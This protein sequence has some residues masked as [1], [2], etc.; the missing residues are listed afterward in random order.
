M[1]WC[2]SDNGE[3]TECMY[4]R[5]GRG[6]AYVLPFCR[7][8]RPTWCVFCSGFRRALPRCAGALGV[9]LFLRVQEY[10]EESYVPFMSVVIDT[11]A[12]KYLL[13]TQ[14]APPLRPFHDMLDKAR[15]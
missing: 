13:E 11:L 15:R 9:T 10:C 2:S 3:R 12:F 4:A 14:D 5:G 6:G 8:L 7:S 1:F